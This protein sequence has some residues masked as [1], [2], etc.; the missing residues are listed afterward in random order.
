MPRILGGM[1]NITLAKVNNKVYITDYELIPLVTHQQSGY[2]TTYKLED[3]T[4][5]LCSK[6]K[7]YSKGLSTAYLY[8]LY[9]KIMGH[10]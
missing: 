4:D 6:H 5:D 3:Y 1:A 7:L 10:E 8:E 2:I 9:D